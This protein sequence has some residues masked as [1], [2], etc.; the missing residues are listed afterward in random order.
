MASKKL[1]RGRQLPVSDAGKA[2][3][4]R[5][6]T[7]VMATYTSIS[8]PMTAAYTSTSKSAPMLQS[9]YEREQNYSRE[10]PQPTAES[11]L[12]TCTCNNNK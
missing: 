9:T 2:K 3:S 10:E 11:D 8:T 12:G 6:S 1:K 5:I 4:R 7:P